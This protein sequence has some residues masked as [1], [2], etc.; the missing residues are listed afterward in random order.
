[1]SKRH[2]TLP[3]PARPQAGT[4]RA[5]ECARVLGLV[6]GLEVALGAG[7]VGGAEAEHVARFLFAWGGV[8]VGTVTLAH[9]PGEGGY[10]YGSRHL[11]RR[12]DHGGERVRRV[13]LVLGPEGRVVGGG[14]VPQALWLW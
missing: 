10:S 11:R 4:R 8:P 3:C 6:L 12:G 9:G 1:M 7:S 14:G 5:G 2:R 13:A